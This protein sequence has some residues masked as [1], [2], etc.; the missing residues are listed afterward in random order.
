M[1]IRIFSLIVAGLVLA[2][3]QAFFG[4][5]LTS[6]N[7]KEVA[8]VWVSSRGNQI[9]LEYTSDINLRRLEAR[10]RTRYF[11]VSAVERDL[12]TN[13]SYDTEKRIISRLESILLRTEQVLAMYPTSVEIKIKIFSTN[14]QPNF[15]L[16]HPGWISYNTQICS[17][18]ICRA[19]KK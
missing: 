19:V 18:L 11:S 10:L 2:G 13:P 4:D 6:I 5:T 3:C 17:C 8:P 1:K 12:F 14:A 16:L 9:T 7:G 15:A